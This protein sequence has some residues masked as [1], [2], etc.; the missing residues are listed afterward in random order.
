MVLLLI[1]LILLCTGSLPTWSYSRAWGYLPSAGIG[2][3][4][5]LCALLL[6][7]HLI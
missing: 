1:L 6:I 4:A 5:L 7:M 3:I 2:I